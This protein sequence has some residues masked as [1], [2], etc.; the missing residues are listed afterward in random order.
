VSKQELYREA[1]ERA[2]E[3]LRNEV[4]S[5]RVGRLAAS[6]AEGQVFVECNGVAKA[7][8]LLSGMSRNELAKAENRGRGVLLIFEEGDADRPIIVGL[9]EDP[10]DGLVSMEVP[11]EASSH[12]TEAKVDGKRVTIEAQE[13]IV[14]KCGSGSITLR[15]DG[16][17]VIKGTHLLSRSSGPIRVKGARVDIN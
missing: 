5:P 3:T 10:L 9:M 14:L 11:A 7:A 6:G 8:R 13:E 15:K 12:P 16:K 4:L 17:I 1:I 2:G